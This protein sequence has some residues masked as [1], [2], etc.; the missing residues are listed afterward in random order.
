MMQPV[1]CK[2]MQEFALFAMNQH[3]ADLL[4][5]APAEA[6]AKQLKELHLRVNV[7]EKKG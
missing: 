6:T 1:V 5:G 2:V 4:M 7:L 3:A